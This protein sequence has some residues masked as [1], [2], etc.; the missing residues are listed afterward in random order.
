MEPFR[1]ASLNLD[2]LAGDGRTWA[3]M[4]DDERAGEDALFK[5]LQKEEQRRLAQAE[6]EANI[7]Q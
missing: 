4:L 3:E 6:G 5:D 7:A 1:M 2:Q